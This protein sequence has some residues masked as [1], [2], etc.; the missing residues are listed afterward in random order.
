MRPIV[1]VIA[2]P[3]VLSACMGDKQK[4]FTV[5]VVTQSFVEGQTGSAL[6]GCAASLG[7]AAAKEYYDSRFGGVV[8]REDVTATMAGCTLTYRF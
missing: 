1:F 5:G 2:V 8:D 6:K 3:L 4:H 7:L